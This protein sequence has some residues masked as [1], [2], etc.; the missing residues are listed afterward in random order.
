MSK[1]TLKAT[2]IILQNSTYGTM[3]KGCDEELKQ[4]TLEE[5][6]ERF[7]PLAK[8]GSMWMPS[9]DDC[10]KANKQEGFIEGAKWQQERNYSDMEEYSAFV[11]KSYK[12]GLPLLLAKEWFQQFKKK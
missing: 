9:A 10:N 7:Y 11:L 3:G 6:A 8:G 1:E 2:M 5:A 4:E 12:E